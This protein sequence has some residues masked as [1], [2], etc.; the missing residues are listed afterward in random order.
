MRAMGLEPVLFPHALDRGPLYF[1]GTTEER[2]DDLHA[3]FADSSI[4]AIICTRGGY[5]S[6]RLLPLLDAELIRGNAKPFIGYSDHTSLHSWIQNAAGL[7]TFHGPMV[8]ADFARDGG[9][10]EAS[11]R[12]ALS[13]D[14][15]WQLC[16]S[17]GLRVLKPG[18]AEGVLLGGCLSLLTASLGTPFEAETGAG[19]MFIEDIGAKPYQ[20][21]RMLLQWQWAGKLRG[22]KGIVFGYMQNCMQPGA[23]ER[24]LED[25]ILYGLAEFDGPVAIGLRSGHV[26]GANI[27]LPLGVSVALD[28]SERE[29]PLLKFVEPAA[30]RR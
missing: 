4:D 24:L 16:A 1:A 30:I 21:E 23:P 22:V 20:I 28:L 18:K 2:V 15:S 9:V 13:G 5:G 12:H 17:D 6:A 3:A 10:D 19:I 11:W 27:M 26:D 29:R 8:A 14:A 7:V 25:A